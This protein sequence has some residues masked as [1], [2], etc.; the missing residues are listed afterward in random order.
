MELLK[1][2]KLFSLQPTC[3][4]MI[5]STVA[6]Q[7]GLCN[8]IQRMAAIVISDYI[9]ISTSLDVHKSTTIYVIVLCN[10]AHQ[11]QSTM[12]AAPIKDALIYRIWYI[13]HILLHFNF[14]DLPFLPLQK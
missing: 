3:S 6:L 9:P 4:M 10:C 13:L 8:A 1:L 11:E 14:A 5:H 7:L 12:D 2:I